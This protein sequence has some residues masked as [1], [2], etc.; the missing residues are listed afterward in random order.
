MILRSEF[1]VLLIMLFICSVSAG[2]FGLILLQTF[3]PLDTN[4]VVIATYQQWGLFILAISALT[5]NAPDWDPNAKQYLVLC[6]IIELNISINQFNNLG[7]NSMW[8]MRFGD[9]T[10]F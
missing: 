9:N 5:F 4:P 1:Q 7:E 3:Y 8:I 2:S 10:A 6:L